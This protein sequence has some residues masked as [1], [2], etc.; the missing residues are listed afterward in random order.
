MGY[1]DKISPY[2]DYNEATRT[3]VSAIN[4]PSL[5]QIRAMKM[6]ANMVFDPVREH[7]GKPIKVNSFFRSQEVNVMIG[8][9]TTSQHCRGEAIDMDGLQGLTNKEIF[10]YIRENLVFDQLIWE[11]GTD[12]NP[13]WVHVSYSAK[14]NRGQVLKS[15]KVDGKTK[16]LPYE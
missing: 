2:I 3:K 12:E 6:A 15:V 11:F 5:D 13:D 16:Y 14:Q 4:K 7:F 8:G 1:L 10:D 9:S